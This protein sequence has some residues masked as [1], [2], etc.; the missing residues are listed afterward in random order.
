MNTLPERTAWFRGGDSLCETSPAPR[1]RAYR[2]VLLGP[3]GVGK[4]TQ[5]ELLW[6]AL[7]SGWTA[8]QLEV[9]L[10]DHTARHRTG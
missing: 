5:A 1:G 8:A 9:A 4:G 6:R 10:A 2:L 3:P 7:E